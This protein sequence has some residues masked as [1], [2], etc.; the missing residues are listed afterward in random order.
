VAVLFNNCRCRDHAGLYGAGAFYDR[1][2]VGVQADMPDEPG[3]L[4]RVQFG[5][6]VRSE[7]LPMA[8]A[9]TT[10]PYA[11]FFNVNGHF[12]QRSVI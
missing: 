10:A 2:V 1:G 4:A 9:A 5:T 11:A 7:Q 3:T 12:K 6:W 8:T